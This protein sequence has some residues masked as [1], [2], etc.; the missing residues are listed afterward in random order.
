M[1]AAFKGRWKRKMA[2]RYS[3]SAV[4]AEQANATG[5]WSPLK[6]SVF[7]MLWIATVVSNTATWIHEVG[8]AWLMTSLAPSPLMVSLIQVATSL[9]L[10]FL[11]LP[12][13]ALA[14]IVNRRR[15]LIVTQSWMLITAAGMATITILG[16]TNPTSLLLFTFA[17]GIGAALN[18]PA[19]QAIVPELVPR[20]QLSAAVALNSVGFNIARAVGPAV[21][22][23]IVAAA[24]SQAAFALNAVSFLGVIFV[25]SKWR[26]TKKNSTLPPEQ[27]FG[28]M[29]VGVRY[30]RYAPNF[31]NVLGRAVLFI[32]PASAL[33]A[34]LPLLS[35]QELG[36]G[37]SGF[38][39]LLGAVGAG[40][41]GGAFL[42][43]KLRKKYSTD[44]VT[45]VATII[46]GL[47]LMI[48]S[49]VSS[50]TLLV[51][52]MLISGMTWLTLLSSLNVGAQAV[53][54]PWVRARALSVYLICFFGSM[55][56]GSV[57]WG[58]LANVTS[59]PVVLLTASIV[60]MAGVTLN[61]FLPLAATEDLNLS[62]S[63]HW[64]TPD[65]SLEPEDSIQHVLTTIEYYIDPANSAEFLRIMKQLRLRRLKDGAIQWQLYQDPSVKGRYWE[66]FESG[67]WLEHLRHHERVSE[68]DKDLQEEALAFHIRKAPPKVTHLLRER[69]DC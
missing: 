29:M 66:C 49:L 10:F 30:A 22:G 56:F 57:A 11:A 21:G 4:D 15:L 9:P 34:L 3:E 41:L 24:G 65:I 36:L 61:R 50:I 58:G 26:G 53:S 42:L 69:T 14:D 35:R 40:A 23:V 31:R 38:G 16:L 37:A 5:P 18:A 25:L 13:G 39:G 45:G 51:L 20:E 6:I 43:P 1:G 32:F 46:F 47:T 2:K 62:P 12:A 63:L 17:L 27:F 52:S 68:I 8:A 44:V 55:A 67:S 48:L 64:P 7:R 60:C 28:A 19:W 33:W 59:I 54:A